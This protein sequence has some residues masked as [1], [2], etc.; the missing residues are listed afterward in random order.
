M[1]I[2]LEHLSQDQRREIAER[3]F[4]VSKHDQGRG[5]L[6][7]H[8]PLHEDESPS[9]SYNY[10]KDVFNCLGCG[11]TG[12]S[13]LAVAGSHGP[14]FQRILPGA[15]H[16]DRKRSRGR[17]QEGQNGPGWAEAQKD[18]LRIEAGQVRA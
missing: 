11:A 4:S 8:C 15:R 1:G 10:Q 7:G 9:F 17:V 2:S 13:G 12:G 6:I 5:E 16:Q 14:G 3:L 18:G